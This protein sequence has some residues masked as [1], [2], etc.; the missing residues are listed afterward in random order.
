MIAKLNAQ[1]N[2]GVKSPEFK[3]ALAKLHDEPL[4]GTPLDFTNTIKADIAKWAPI[5]SALGL[6]AQ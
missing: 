2:E 6:K 4:G 1:I 5:V 3:A